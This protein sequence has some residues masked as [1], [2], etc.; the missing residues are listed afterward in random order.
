M[1]WPRY[2]EKA[3]RYLQ[4]YT[5]GNNEGQVKK[6]L[7]LSNQEGLK[8]WKGRVSGLT[9]LNIGREKPGTIWSHEVPSIS[10]SAPLSL[11]LGMLESTESISFF[12]SLKDLFIYS[13]ET[14]SE[15]ERQRPGRGRSKLPT[16]GP[17]WDS[18]PDPRITTWAKGRRP[19]AKPPRRPHRVHFLSQART[20]VMY[21]PSLLSRVLSTHLPSLILLSHKVSERPTLSGTPFSLL[22]FR[23]CP[24]SYLRFTFC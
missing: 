10:V 19:T 21:L 20:Q 13:W 18:I 5:G 2:L 4:V 6:S 3:P 14:Q 8:E 12:L 7:C 22:Q 11:L 17:M 1:S 9:V 24:P 16:G 23:R 15:R